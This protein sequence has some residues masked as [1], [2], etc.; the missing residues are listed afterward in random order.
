M[1]PGRLPRA[2]ALGAAA[3][4]VVACLCGARP[5]GAE[6]FF[7]VLRSGDCVVRLVGLPNDAPTAGLRLLRDETETDIAP[8]VTMRDGA[9]VVEF[10]LRDPLIINSQLK[11]TLSSATGEVEVATGRVDQVGSDRS[12]CQ[13]FD[14]RG[15]FEPLLFYGVVSDAFAPNELGDY[16]VGTDYPLKVSQIARLEAQIRPFGTGSSWLSGLWL[17]VEAKYGVRSADLDCQS[18]IDKKSPACDPSN[19]AFVPPENAGAAF[20]ANVLRAS[21]IEALFKPRLEVYT[22]NADGAAP[23]ALLVMGRFG[24]SQLPSDVKPRNTFAG[25]GGFVFPSGPFRNSGFTAVFGKD[26]GFRTNPGAWRTRMDFRFLFDP[27]S[28][29]FDQIPFVPHPSRGV[30]GLI[31]VVVDRNFFGEGPDAFQTYLGVVLDMRQLLGG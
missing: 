3:A 17:D 27:L 25:G 6:G 10:P 20:T 29:F 31:E 11:A 26:Q 19:S 4:A 9:M 14:E 24:L 16:P 13:S 8:S 5:A 7:E 12:S 2:R 28:K 21:R 23:I 22:L 18:E 30:R 15:D 1:R